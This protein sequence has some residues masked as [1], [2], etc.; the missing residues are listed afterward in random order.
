MILLLPYISFILPFYY[1]SITLLTFKH[2][3]RN[4]ESV[5]NPGTYSCI[6]PMFVLSHVDT[7][8]ATFRS[9]V[10]KFH[11]KSKNMIRN[12]ENRRPRTA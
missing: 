3:E 12:P 1:S 7:D 5:S 11:A 4:F 2:W 6:L 10:Q 8:S 9:L